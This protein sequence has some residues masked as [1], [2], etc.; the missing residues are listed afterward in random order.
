MKNICFINTVKFWGGGEKFYLD[1]A[2]GLQNKGY[3]VFLICNQKSILG[4]RAERNN[5]PTYYMNNVGNLSFLNPLKL[6]KLIRFF[7]N[8]KIDIVIFSAS[9][10]FKLGGLSSYLAKVGKRIY[11]RGLAIPINNN[12]LNRFLLQKCITH[13]NA[14]SEETKRT[15]LKNLSGGLSPD[16]IKVIYNGI[17][18]IPENGQ[19]LREMEIIQE[20]GKGVILGNAGRLVEQ[21]GQIYLIEIARKLRNRNLPFT[22]FIAGAGSLRQRLEEEISRY[23]LENDVILLGFVDDIVGF[24]KSID[25]FLLTSEWEG[26]GYVL[27]EAMQCSKPVVAFDITSNPEIVVNNISGY[28]VEYPDL[29]EFT[30]K[31]LRLAENPTIRMSMGKAGR[32]KSLEKFQFEKTFKQFEDYITNA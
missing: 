22:I 1:Y 9:R 18:S 23:N 13:I 10:D 16:K 11:R 19:G 25:I 28:L 29:D 24:M 20:K 3:K 4:K 7:K 21:K 2:T 8:N 31:V 27:V 14:N 32:H 5:I 26:F 17:K 15:I 12:F 30:E 6:Y